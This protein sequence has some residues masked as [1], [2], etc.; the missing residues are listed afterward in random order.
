MAQANDVEVYYKV[1]SVNSQSVFD[2]IEWVAFNGNG[3]PDIEVVPTNEAAISGL[4][5]SQ[6][7]YKEHK[8]SIS[9]LNEFASFAVK[10]VMKSANPCYIPKIQDARI[11][12]AF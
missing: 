3:L 8:Y 6:S 10:I 7:S 5:E 4:F 9:N 1:K 12:A 11:I 2:D